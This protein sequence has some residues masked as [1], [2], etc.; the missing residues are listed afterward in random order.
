M[1]A[2]KSLFQVADDKDDSVPSCF[3]EVPPF[4]R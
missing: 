1:I 3:S 4:E 2:P